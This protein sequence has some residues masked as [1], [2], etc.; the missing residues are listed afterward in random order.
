MCLCLNKYGVVGLPV[1][2]TVVLV[3]SSAVFSYLIFSVFFLKNEAD[4]KLVSAEIDI[5]VS[6]AKS[7]YEHANQG[8]VSRVRIDIPSSVN[9]IVFGDMPKKDNS[10]PT[11]IDLDIEKSNNYYFV[12]ENGEIQSFSSFVNFCGRNSDE[13]SILYPGRYDVTLELVKT[14]RGSYVKIYI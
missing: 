9:F 1:Y 11:D 5:I 8:T 3:V 12:M 14:S 13:I 7:M 10:L 6:E 2:L 4:E